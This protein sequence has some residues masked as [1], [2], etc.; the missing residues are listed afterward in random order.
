M[1]RILFLVF[2]AVSAVVSAQLASP[3]SAVKKSLTYQESLKQNSLV[4]NLYFDN[5]GPTVMSGRVVDVDVNPNNTTEYYVAYASGGLWYTNNNGT[6]FEPVMD[7][8]STQNIGDIAVDWPT[9]TI[10]IGTG[11]NNSSRSSYA[12]V[13]ML[14]STD[15]GKTWEHMGLEDSHHIGRILINPH[16]P[17]EV[18]V[19]VLGHLYSKNDQ[20]G[21]YKTT[22]GGRT[23][24][25]TLSISNDTGIVDLDAAPEDFN[26]I[27]AAAWEKDR[28]AWDFKG[29]GA[30]SGIYKSVDAGANWVL[31]STTQSGFPSGKGTGR[32]GL[33]VYDKNT[34]YAVHDSQFHMPKNESEEIE[35]DALKKDDFKSMKTTDFLALADGA[36]NEYL[37]GNNFPKKYNAKS[38]KDLIKNKAAKP[39]DLALYLEDA[40]SSLFDTPIIGAE[41]FLTTDGGS[42]WK[43]QNESPIDGLFYTYGY[44]FAQIAV[45][46]TN[47]DHIIIGG[48]PLLASDDG[49]KTYLSISGDNMHSD[50]HSIWIN[51]EN[52][53]H[54]I[55]GNDGGINI[56]YDR[57]SHWLKSNTPAVGQFYFITT[58]NQK[59]YNVYGGLQDNGVWKGAHNAPKNTS[60][61]SNGNYPWKSIIGGDG[62]QVQ[63]DSRDNNIVY[64]GFQFGNYFR[65]N[66]N[67]KDYQPIQPKHKLGETPLR[68]NWQ[69]P[70]LLSTHHQDILYLGSN[71]LHRSM[72]QGEHWETIS[73]DLT[74]GGKKGNVPYG[75]LSVIEES[76]FQ[77]GKL[78]VGSD[79]GMIYRTN[80][81]GVNWK[82]ISKE[83]PSEQWVSSIFASTH[84]E[85][86]VY[87]S[88]NAY[89]MDNFTPYIYASEN[90]GDNWNLIST[91]LPLGAVNSVIEDPS[92]EDILYIGTDNGAYVSFDRGMSWEAFSNNLPAVAIHD[93]VVQKE[94]KHLLLGTHGRSI[95]KADIS[96]IQQM[97]KDLRAKDL[98]LF[99]LENRRHS[100]RWGNK[101]ASWSTAGTPK[102]EVSFYLKKQT[103]INLE[104]QHISGPKVYS[105]TID[106]ITGLNLHTYDLSFS[107]EGLRNYQSEFKQELQKADNGVYYLPKGSYKVILSNG[108]TTTEQEF[109]IE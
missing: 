107:K 5:I 87:M 46:K 99:Q 59:P 103:K 50:H 102:L 37:R 98:H 23:W 73:G 90:S 35:S 74:R 100:T 21:V 91:S 42:S 85:G 22:D 18:I 72:D 84:K 83:L 38:V 36:L 96:K 78:Y 49:G 92:N 53:Q 31:I 93:V 68:F 52:D 66:L 61:H 97:D 29:S 3:A 48:V 80:D 24:K 95:Y 32:I 88:L 2:T 6:S 67:T 47:M 106:A 26:V 17:N 39:S 19:G 33:A 69:T 51:P 57:G 109:K 71:K 64:T 55:N 11:E 10:W 77:F 30:H 54:I 63:V 45:S 43:K 1:K 79:D 108:N 28:K 104:V 8:A 89:R 34:V 41:V 70:I 58:D 7:S 56:S 101:R 20:R 86:R 12:G 25:K 62:M 15:Q 75:T 16:N 14:K 9:R 105:T 76:P 27:Y 40:N 94:A 44:Y 81:G 82:L 60:W 4:K 13:G 65:V